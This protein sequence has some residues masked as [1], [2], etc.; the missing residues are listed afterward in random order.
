[1]ILGHEMEYGDER[2]ET[3]TES[4]SSATAVRIK[5][6]P[7]CAEQIQLA[8]IKCRYCGEMLDKMS[9]S[10]AP[11]PA[12]PPAATAAARY[13][14]PEPLA[15]AAAFER[16][17]SSGYRTRPRSGSFLW[18]NS[19][20]GRIAVIIVAVIVTLFLIGFAI[21][22]VQGFKKGFNQS[23]NNSHAIGLYTP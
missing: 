6:C 4:R 12:E 23:Y 18:P 20:L 22:F 9:A 17:S 2:S 15:T 8:A 16:T 3:G 11:A 13:E 19:V 1:L 14:A 5:R 10:S 21:G 7:F